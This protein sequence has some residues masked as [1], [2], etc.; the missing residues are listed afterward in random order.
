MYPSWT[1]EFYSGGNSSIQ[2]MQKVFVPQ[3]KAILLGGLNEFETCR[4][5][6]KDLRLLTLPSIYWKWYYISSISVMMYWRAIK[7]P[8]I[9]V[10]ILINNTG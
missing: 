10:T 7:A 6:F 3:K 9:L 4:T 5:A 1:M 2:N 8:E